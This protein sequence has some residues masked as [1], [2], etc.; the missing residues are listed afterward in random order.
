MR[1]SIITI[2]YNNADGLKRTLQS[3]RTQTYKNFEYIVIDG[4]SIDASVEMIK[5]FASQADGLDCKWIS[6]PDKGVYDAMNKG[7][8]MA[9][10]EYCL[11]LNAGDILANDTALEVLMANDLIADI[12]S[13]NA[14]YEKSQY[15]SGR[16]VLSPQHIKASDLI[17]HFLPHQATLIKRE[18]FTRIHLYDTSF[19]VVSDWLFF[20]EALLKYDAS[21]QHVQMFLSRCETQ[22]ISSNPENNQ[23]MNEEFHRGLKQVLPLYYEDYAKMRAAG[24]SG[25]KDRDKFMGKLAASWCGRLL[26]KVRNVFKRLGY[27]HHKHNY[28]RR[29]F[30]KQLQKEDQALKREIAE[31]IEALP[32]SMLHR[33]NNEKDVIISLTSYG[34]RVSDTAPYAIYSIFTQSVIP[35]RIVLWLDKEHW[36][37]DNLPHLIKRLRQSG[38]EIYYCDDLRSYKK[39]IPSLKMFPNNP[40]V[41]ID[42]DFYYHKDFV[43]WMVEAYEQSD[44]RTVFATWG[45]IPEQADGK[46]L[47]YSQWKDCEY[48]N[49][50]TEYSLFG[51]G[52]IYPPHIF[53]EEVQN[54]KVFMSLCPTA[55][56][57]WFWA[58]EKRLGIKTC[59]TEHH[60]YGLHRMVNRIE[61]YDLTQTGTLF[62]QNCVQGKNDEQLRKVIEYYSLQ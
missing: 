13:C 29:R 43:K 62:Y 58:Q 5:S 42:D 24:M 27:Y 50:H 25:D 12:V 49:E 54:E 20:I 30:Y 56:D 55:D 48:G 32:Q 38:L 41:V 51:G 44:K 26:W 31:K 17:L 1:L 19:K 28:T 2:T 8:K 47:P 36:N 15:Q 16:Y 59:L 61:E 4:A 60:G 39:L 46:Y 37:D 7:I 40:I 3:V 22:G 23:M 18:L 53:D 34:K 6:E 57:I 10:G 9:H 14:I 52:S 35:N 33:Q 21:Y 11:F 45:C